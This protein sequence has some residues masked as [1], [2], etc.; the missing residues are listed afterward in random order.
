MPVPALLMS[1]DTNPGPLREAEVNGYELLH[2]P[3]DP[4]ALRAMLIKILK[5]PLHA[6]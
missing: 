1:G 4:A 2:K 3:V 5:Q 6:H